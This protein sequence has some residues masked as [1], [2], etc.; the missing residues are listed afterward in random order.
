VSQR[1]TAQSARDAWARQR[2]HI[3][4][5]RLCYFWKEICTGL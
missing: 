1:S 2:L 5:G 4:N 3:C